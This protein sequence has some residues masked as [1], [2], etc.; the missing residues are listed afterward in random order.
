MCHFTYSEHWSSHTVRHVRVLQKEELLGLEMRASSH[1]PNYRGCSTWRRFHGS[2]VLSLQNWSFAQ[3][4]GSWRRSQWRGQLLGNRRAFLNF[5]SGVDLKWSVEKL[6]LRHQKWILTYMQIFSLKKRSW[7]VPS[8]SVS[9]GVFC[10]EQQS[11]HCGPCD[12]TRTRLQTALLLIWALPSLPGGQQLGALG[13]SE[14]RSGGRVGRRGDRAAHD[15][16]TFIWVRFTLPWALTLIAPVP[17]LLQLSKRQ[18]RHKRLRDV[19]SSDLSGIRQNCASRGVL[20]NSSW[21]PYHW[22]PCLL[23]ARAL[24]MLKWKKQK[25][26]K[27]NTTQQK[28]LAESH[29]CKFRKG[30]AA[31][32]NRLI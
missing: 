26:T 3:C 2:T 5:A 11:A 17:R 30:P 28:K 21:G 4:K 29:R 20:N 8:D 12:S 13:I 9:Y 1:Q 18:R 32:T 23:K 16:Q 27:P 22:K 7:L 6:Q 14:V 25:K 19:N 31:F 24:R 10:R 15:V